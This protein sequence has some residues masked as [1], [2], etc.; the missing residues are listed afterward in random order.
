LP[1]LSDIFVL[2]ILFSKAILSQVP[3]ELVEIKPKIKSLVVHSDSKKEEN[4][5][6]TK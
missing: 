2:F 4:F 1:G 6:L 3:Q 5:L